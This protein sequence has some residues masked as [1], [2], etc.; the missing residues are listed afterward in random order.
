MTLSTAVD[1]GAYGLEF[2]NSDQAPLDTS[3]FLDDRSETPI[4][5]FTVL[6]DTNGD[7]KVGVYS[8]VY[9][10]YLVDYEEVEAIQTTPFTIEVIDPCGLESENSLTPA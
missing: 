4:N 10:V 3:I 5:K 7:L 6:K 9:R 8:I 1:C 2:L